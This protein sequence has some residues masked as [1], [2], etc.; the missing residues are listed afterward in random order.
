MTIRTKGVLKMGRLD[1]ALLTLSEDNVDGEWARHDAVV[2]CTQRG[3]CEA[4]FA[5]DGCLELLTPELVEAMVSQ[6]H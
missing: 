2:E 5:P 1:L 4:W 3:C 6:T